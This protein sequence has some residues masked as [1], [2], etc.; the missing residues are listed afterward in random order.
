MEEHLMRHNRTVY[1]SGISYRRIVPDEYRYVKKYIYILMNGKSEI[2]S[3]LVP[4][5]PRNRI[6]G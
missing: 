6:N 1:V 3:V 5:R 4:S 2:T